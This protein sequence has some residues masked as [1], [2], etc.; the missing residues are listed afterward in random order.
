MG[1]LDL[2]IL[3]IGVS[4]DA[5]SVAICK[6]LSIKKVTIK[7]AVIVGLY[8]GIFQAGMP[9]I[10]YFLGAQ[11]QEKIAA[12]DHWIAFI[13]LSFI[14]TNMIIESKKSNC[15]S[16]SESKSNFNS[17][18]SFSN[19][20]VSSIA[21]SIDALAIGITLAFLNVD[22]LPAAILIGVVTFTISAVGV[23]IGS[24]FG[25]LYKSKAEF[26]GGSILILIGLKILLEHLEIINF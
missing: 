24:V 9:L 16:E 6:G 1:F 23:K 21:T 12:V 7:E 10:G 13:L 14:G 20:V 25:S 22:I 18:L 19:M 11:F 8:F 17:S 3:A 4:M 2:F 26:L 15:N 5:F